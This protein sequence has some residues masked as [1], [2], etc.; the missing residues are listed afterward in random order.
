MKH[1]STWSVFDVVVLVVREHFRG[2]CILGARKSISGMS[3]VDLETN[4]SQLNVWAWIRMAEFRNA[5]NV[6]AYRLRL[7]LIV[8]AIGYLVLM[9]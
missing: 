8:T 1:L 9:L 7:E 2:V 5:F 6:S 3:L 4:I